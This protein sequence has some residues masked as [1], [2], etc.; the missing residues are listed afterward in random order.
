MRAKVICAVYLS[1]QDFTNSILQRPSSGPAWG[2]AGL[3]KPV[4]GSEASMQ[5]KEF[6][7]LG[8]QP[9]VPPVP[10]TAEAEGVNQSGLDTSSRQESQELSR[11]EPADRVPQKKAQVR[12]RSCLVLLAYYVM[13]LLS[14]EP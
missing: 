5:S 9:A 3:P 10:A 7:G 11:Q 6:P 12:Q 2:G 13:R 4:Q 8:E 1:R 14:S